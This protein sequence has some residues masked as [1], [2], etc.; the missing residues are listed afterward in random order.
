MGGG[1]IVAQTLTR[2]LGTDVPLLGKIPFDV[3]LREGGDNG[4]PL[5]LSSPDAPASLVLTQIAESLGKRPRG[6][7]GL[8]LGI[9]P[10]RRV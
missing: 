5:V 7:A 9:T 2:Q 10:A 6:L 8:S 1:A 3:A 4:Q